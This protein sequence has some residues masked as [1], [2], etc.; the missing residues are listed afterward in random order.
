MGTISESQIN[1]YTYPTTFF[2]N[3]Y[4]PVTKIIAVYDFVGEGCGSS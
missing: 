1:A 4:L 2:Q 3:V